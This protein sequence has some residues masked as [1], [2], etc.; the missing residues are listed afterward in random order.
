MQESELDVIVQDWG[1]FVG[2]LLTF[3][4]F[5]IC[6]IG[7]SGGG[8]DPD[9]TG[10]YNEDGALNIFGYNTSMDWDD[11]LG[12]GLNKWY[13]KEGQLIMPPDS[14]ER[15]QHY[16][17]WQQ[18]LMDKILPC[19]PTFVPNNYMAIWSNLDGYN[20][21]DGVI[22]SFGKMKFTGL[23]TEQE[24]SSKLVVA[25]DEWHELN[26]FFYSDSASAFISNAIMDPLIYYDAEQKA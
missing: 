14:S 18:H 4:D 24:D 25:D 13:M 1:V 16:W 12:T 9:F 20:I 23:H 7:I 11:D 17:D 6:Y 10:V 2:E 19:Q 8:A 5:D 22:N 26:P 3:R 21:S 15:L